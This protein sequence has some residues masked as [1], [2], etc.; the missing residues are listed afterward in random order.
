MYTLNTDKRRSNS[1][2]FRKVE[3]VFFI[4]ARIKIIVKNIENQKL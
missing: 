2:L 3:T 1:N 4:C